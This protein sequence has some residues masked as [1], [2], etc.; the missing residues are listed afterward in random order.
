MRIPFFRTQLAALLICL[1][2]GGA[3][4]RAPHAQTGS[5]ASDSNK[6]AAQRSAQEGRPALTPQVRARM[7]QAA[8]AVGLVSVSDKTGAVRPRGSGVVVRKDGIIV[9]NLHV[10]TRDNSEEEY[11]ELFFS[12]A[13]DIAVPPP[14]EPRYRLRKLEV[15]KQRDLV[16]LRAEPLPLPAGEKGKPAEL[17]WPSLEVGNVKALQALDDLIVIGFPEKGGETVTINPGV[18]EGFDSGGEWIK[19]DARLLHGDSGGAAVSNEGKLIGIATKVEV[20]KAGDSRLGAVGYLRPASLVTQMLEK[21]SVSEAAAARPPATAAKTPAASPVAD[22][23]KDGSHTAGGPS[24]PD[25][26]L[27]R[28]TV[29]LAGTGAPIAGARVGLILAGREVSPDTVVAWGGTNADGFFKMEKPVKPGNYTLRARVIGDER[30]AI[31]NLEIEIK[32]DPAPLLIELQPAK[33]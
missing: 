11:P 23:V 17:N 32:S 7:R 25:L 20:D 9:T 5:S 26:V 27:V 10:I 14:S 22:A 4:S 30:F 28:G 3:A 31:F 1:C 29:R 19:T 13:A 2:V 15:D 24:Q 33:K 8:A 16:L 6:R 21:L 18:I 12:L